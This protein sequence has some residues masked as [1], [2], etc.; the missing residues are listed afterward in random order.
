[1]LIKAK[2][3]KSQE[4]SWAVNLGFFSRIPAQEVMQLYKSSD[5]CVS[6]FVK[7]QLSRPQNK[8]IDNTTF[9]E[10]QQILFFF[11]FLSSF[12]FSLTFSF[13]DWISVSQPVSADI[14]MF[15]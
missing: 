6:S 12:F 15:I 5:K 14:L 13:N 11:F 8:N 7:I 1:M 9:W 2:T 10:M 4:Y 3:F